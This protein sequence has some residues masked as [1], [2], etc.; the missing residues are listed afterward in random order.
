[1]KPGRDKPADPN[2]KPFDIAE[3][4]S[5]AESVTA[6][7]QRASTL[8]VELRTS[9]SSP[10]LVNTLQGSIDASV[11]KAA[12]RSARLV[13]TIFWRI[14]ALLVLAFVLALLYRF[15]SNAMS[16]RQGPPA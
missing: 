6:T 2:A 15:A 11:D 8:L 9:L 16:R 10:E 5:A 12:D 3:Y 1:M 7:L 13:D 4:A 14:A